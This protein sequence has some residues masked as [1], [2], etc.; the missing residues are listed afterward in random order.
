MGR[1]ATVYDGK[2]TETYGYDPTSG[3]LVAMED[4]AAGLF[5][6]GYNADGA[7]TEQGLPN[8]LVAKATYDEAGA[9]TK[10]TYTK[11]TRTEKCTWLE[12][13]EERSIRG[14]V[15]SQKSL[16]S[17]RQYSYDK[18]GRLTVAKETPTGG[19]CTTRTYAFEG[20][21]GKDSNR[22]SLTTRTPGV[23]GA[24]AESGGTTQN[25]KYDAADR[26]TGE[27]IA[28]DNFGRIT[29]LPSTYAG[30]ST[31]ETT[32]YSNE[33]LASQSQ[34][35]LTNSYQLDAT[36]RD[37]QVTQ[38]GT[39]TG[40]EIFHYSM[41]SDS[42][43]W[44]ERGGTW[45]RS[46]GGIGGGLAAIQESSGTTSLQLTNLHGDVVAT[47]SLSVGERTDFEL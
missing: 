30:G 21:A 11:V 32:F 42:T 1:P 33:M 8:G 18:A 34:G 41:G 7:M 28:Y 23:G 4:S 24:C 12:E 44:T 19:G 6:A 27:G 14:Q 47:A 38:T 3:L 10:L 17:S 22:T 46:I 36:G 31:L 35:G 43:A 45:T 15:F 16:T 9:P 26:L 13:S 39:K 40:T 25:Y 2:G 37:R 29:S 5:T 20:E